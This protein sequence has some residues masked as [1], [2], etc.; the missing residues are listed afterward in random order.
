MKAACL[1][2]FVLFLQISTGQTTNIRITNPEAERVLKGDF[3][4]ADYAPATLV[5]HPEEVVDALVQTISPD[6]LRAYLEVMSSFGSRN[7]GSDT[8]SDNFGIG[9]ARRWAYETFQAMSAANDN[10]LL[11]SYVQFDRLICGAAQHRNVLAILPGQGPKARELVLVE[12][13]LDSRCADRCDT[14]CDAQGVEDNVSGSAL[15]LELARTMAPL[16]FNRSIAFLLTTGEEQGL[17]GADAFAEYCVRENAKLQAVFN[18][19]I[20]GGT[21]CGSTAS[22]PGCPGLNHIDS[23]N[24]RIYSAG[25]TSSSKQLARFTKLQYQEMAAPQ[26]SPSNEINI[27]TPEDR[28]G[29]GGDHIPFRERGFPA[30][31]F[32]AANEHGDGDP[33]QAGYEDRQHTVEDVLGLDTD[34]DQLIDSF[35][36][37]FNYLARNTLINGNAIAMAAAGPS[38][39]YDLM[40]EELGNELVVS[41]EDSLSYGNYRLFIRRSDGDQDQDSIIV[42]NRTTDTLRLPGVEVYF[43]S[44]CAVDS[45]G[46]E[47]LFTEEVQKIVFTSTAEIQMRQRGFELLQNRPNPFDEATTFGVYIHEPLPY[48]EAFIQVTDMQGRELVRL[49]IELR[50][51]INEVLYNYQHHRYQPGTYSYSLWVDGRRLATK[52][53]IYAY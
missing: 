22:P 37:D 20:I 39:P 41:F 12:G 42:L 33:S 38:A 45:N 44:A 14:D 47:S 24:V 7:T 15:V 49:P 50:P 5:E 48:R 52:R 36:I 28:I 35:F 2:L 51:G 9:A 19:D 18:N 21:I 4:P 32:T 25:S 1:L 27:M 30:I 10:R 13:H 16:T 40:V 26:L 6:T 43:F 46:I 11:V 29:R 3:D 31:R 34:G 53:M 17:L 23:I 8:L